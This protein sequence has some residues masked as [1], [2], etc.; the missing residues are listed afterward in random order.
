MTRGSRQ[1]RFLYAVAQEFEPEGVYFT[2]FHWPT[3]AAVAARSLHA[4]DFTAVYEAG[5]IHSGEYRR[6]PTSTTE[7]GAYDGGVEMFS[8]S[9]DSLRTYLTSGRLNG[10]ILEAATVDRFGNVNTTVVGDYDAPLIR[11]PGPGGAKDIMT[12]GENVVLVNGST[13]DVRYRDRVQYVSSPGHLDGDGSREAAGY[14]PGTG[15]TTLLTPLARFEFDDG[16]RAQLAALAADTT[17]D[18]VESVTGWNLEPTDQRLPE[19]DADELSV[20]RS[21]LQSANERGYR[22]LRS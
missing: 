8:D 5:I 11:L 21:I 22:S 13:D 20:L 1:E 9:L 2:G 4:P 15:P 17:L 12:H 6:F 7:L 19:P 3:V 16:G 14:D 10:S 18:Q